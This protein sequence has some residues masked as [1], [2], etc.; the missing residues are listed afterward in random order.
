VIE[1]RDSVSVDVI[2]QHLPAVLAELGE[3][4]TREGLQETPLRWAKAL[5]EMTAGYDIDVASVFK[6]F[7][8]EGNGQ[9]VAVRNI[10]V[11]SLCEH[12]VLPFV[13]YCHIG[14]IPNDRILGLSKFA[15]VVDAFARR[16]QVQERLTMQIADAVERFLAPKGVHVIV[17]AEHMCM[18]YRGVQAPGTTTITSDIRG[19]FRDP[20]EHARDE[21]LRLIKE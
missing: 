14:Y 10:P 16:L 20:S 12:H 11:K 5:F 15:R 17:E 13:G 1:S 9:L 2:S 4:P 19:V 7:E 21:F 3:N 18:T 8:H 6:D